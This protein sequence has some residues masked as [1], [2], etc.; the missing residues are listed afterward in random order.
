[1]KSE[2]RTLYSPRIADRLIP[3]L[4]RLAKAKGIPMTQ[5][6]DQLLTQAL[7]AQNE[8]KHEHENV[9]RFCSTGTALSVAESPDNP[10]TPKQRR[11]APR[12]TQNQD[13]ELAYQ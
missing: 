4:Y 9:W 10:P 1:M 13:H 3:R 12:Q 11:N 2:T 5:L 7:A 6:V 8:P